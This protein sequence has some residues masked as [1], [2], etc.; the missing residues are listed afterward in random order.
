MNSAPPPAALAATIFPRCAS[1]MALQ[2]AR[3]SPTPRFLVATSTK[4]GE[5]LAS[6]AKA[7]GVTYERLSQW[8]RGE[9]T[10]S[11]AGRS[12][13]EKAARYLGLPTVLVLALSGGLALQDFVW[14]AK[15]T[16]RERVQLEIERLRQD[17]HIGAFVPTELEKAAPAVQLFVAFLYHQLSPGDPSNGANYKW[18][19]AL[20]DAAAGHAEAQAK[21]GGLNS[22]ATKR[23][24]LF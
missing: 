11:R 2:I 21:L 16:L 12:V 7:L 17:P 23:T 1:T 4:R 6:L 5:T 8:R 19:M 15:R 9:A 13:L 10:I 22:N 24:G 18:L 3:P 14:P 20:H